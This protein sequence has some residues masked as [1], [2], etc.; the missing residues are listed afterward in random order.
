VGI[1]STIQ[2]ARSG[3]LYVRNFSKNEP[4][5]T[6]RGQFSGG[7]TAWVPLTNLPFTIGGARPNN[8]CTS[9]PNVV[10]DDLRIYGSALL[11]AQLDADMG[12][13]SCN[14]SGLIA[15]FKFD[16]GSGATATDCSPD[17]LL[18]TLG[19]GASFVTSPFP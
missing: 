5:H 15:Y 8:L 6:Q 3:F 14:T 19:Q 10:I 4:L 16:E 2:N 18:T 9:A 17:K 13:I 11:A 7:A 12:T 1:I